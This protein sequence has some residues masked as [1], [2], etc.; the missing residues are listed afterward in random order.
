VPAKATERDALGR[1]SVSGSVILE[2]KLVRPPVRSEH[3]VRG[4]LLELLREGAA[5]RLTLLTAPPG[6]GKTTLLAQWASAEE[7]RAVAWLSLDDADNDPTRFL[8]YLIESLRIVE[9]DIGG[10]ALAAH[11]APGAG[12]VD[13]VL[14]LL[15]NDA[16]ALETGI[17]LVLDDYHVITN[18][19]IHEALGF[20]VER[21]PDSLRLVLATRE[22]PPLP[23][24]RL[25]ARGELGELRAAELR[26]T[27]EESRTFLNDVLD[28]GLSA[29][30]VGRLQA[31][32]EGWPAALYLAALS[33]RG[34]DDPRVLI[35][36]F[37][38]DDR[39]L[40]D[41]LTGEVLVRQPPELR[42][43]LLR[44][45]ILVRLCGPLC[46]VVTDR[47]DSALILDELERTNLLLMPLDNK[48]EWYRYH[49]LFAEILQH[50]LER[51]DPNLLPT[52][53]RRASAWHREAGLIVEAAGHA[54]AAGD[55]A[56]AVELVGR[57]ISLFLGQ[58][59]LA[60]VSRWLDALPAHVI[61]EN[62]Q[63]C[64]AAVM[65]A[66]HTSGLDEAERWLEAAERAPPLVRDG[67]APDGPVAASRALLRL[68]RGDIDGTIAAARRALTAGPSA[69]PA[70][71]FGP[72]LL[73]GIAL[74]WSGQT[75]EGKTVLEAATWT[76]EAAELAAG[77]IFTLGLRA[78]ID[79][80][81]G[82]AAQ[83]EELAGVAVALTQR[84]ELEEHPFTAMAQIVH[85]A[86]QGRRGELTEAKDKIER[87]IQ[88]AE[89]ASSWF[90][91]AY[92]LLALAE[93][94]H[95][96]HD[97]AA[98]RRL[99]ARARGI[100]EAL[101]HPGPGLSRVEQTEKALRLR[102]ARRRDAASAPF[103]EL[104]ERELAVLRLLASRLSQREIA[105]E[106]YVSFNTVKSHTRSIFRKLGVDSRADAVNRAREHGLL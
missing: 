23:L 7:G 35:E 93:I 6:F 31:R 20:L 83:A 15:L 27:N 42:S 88:L 81:E 103:W 24:A 45:S 94:R 32:T 97:A 48:R 26:F 30:D 85:G 66:S 72:Q 60:T 52:L 75:T 13:V 73:L 22:D 29:D 90:M 14:P 99:L 8:A 33:V 43:F 2:T 44:T 101:P 25:R 36:G 3:V 82:N 55:V 9:P 76:A 98:A 38:G 87:G 41:Y 5:R 105:A 64:L 92:G 71:G 53:H 63:L 12:P 84:A 91:T 102:A 18:A 19:D 78:A 61:A 95:R 80:D 77:T 28:L 49:Q 50:E 59:H 70:A 68:L 17:V 106:L 51:T 65:V 58:R 56:I 21:L 37:A 100:L 46:D 34:R 39:H 57:H 40:V 54:N 96:E 89:R 16:A 1:S 11:S 47:N 79:L 69:E 4:E 86:V 104:S 74:W 10:R 62:W 67:Q